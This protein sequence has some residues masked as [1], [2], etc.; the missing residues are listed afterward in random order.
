MVKLATDAP[1]YSQAAD[2][3]AQHGQPLLWAP[4]ATHAD[5]GE[6]LVRCAR[7]L[8]QE[9]PPHPCPWGGE[10]G[11]VGRAYLAQTGQLEGGLFGSVQ[12]QRSP[13]LVNRVGRKVV[14]DTPCHQTEG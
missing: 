8:C 5:V 13:R 7:M 11:G 1:C 2:K 9:V 10:V 12:Q 14:Y 6:E 3:Y 4:L